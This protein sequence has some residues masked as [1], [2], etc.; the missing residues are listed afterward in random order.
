MEELECDLV[1]EFVSLPREQEAAWWAVLR[2]VMGSPIPSPT[3][4]TALSASPDPSQFASTVNGEWG[5][6]ESD[7]HTKSIAR[8]GDFVI[9]NSR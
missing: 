2:A 6:I 7:S 9:T 5:E 8:N 3:T 4:S 1:V